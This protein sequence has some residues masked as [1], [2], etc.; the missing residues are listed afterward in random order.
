MPG[1]FGFT[2]DRAAH[3]SQPEAILEAMQEALTPRSSIPDSLFG[4]SWICA[5]RVRG[6]KLQPQPQPA[7]SGE[8]YLWLDGELFNSSEL[9]Q[10]FQLPAGS[11]ASDLEIFLALYQRDPSFTFLKQI[12]GIYSAVLY[13]RAKQ[14][15]YLISDR[16][17]LRPF[18]WAKIGRSL[19]WASEAKAF[20]AMP[21]FQAQIDPAAVEDFLGLRYFIG[22]RSWFKGVELLPAATILSWNLQAETLQQRR[23]WWWDEIAPLPESVNQIEVIEEVGRLFI[24]SVKR[25]TLTPERVGITLSGGLDSRAI[26][27]AMPD[28]GYPIHSVTYGKPGC[29]DVRIASQ[30]AK[31]KASP[32]HIVELNSTNWLQSRIQNVW[33]TD[34]ACSLMHMQ[35]LSALE[36]IRGEDLFDVVLHGTGGGGFLG[37]L[38]LFDP[39]RTDYYVDRQLNLINFARSEAHREAV[40]QRF[41]DYFASLNFSAYILCIDNRIRSFLLKDSR[42][43]FNSGIDCRLP[44]LDNDFQEFLYAIPAAFKADNQL[45]PSMLMRH[46]PEFY[47]HI[48][49]QGLGEPIS[50][51]GLLR[52]T[53]KLYQRVQKKVI[54]EC[55]N[56]G[57]LSQR[58]V[59]PKK[60]ADFH[61]YANWLRQ[62]P[63]RTFVSQL[64]SDRDAIYPEFV[65]REQ[66]QQDWQA[67]LQGQDNNFDRMGQ[68]L[69]FEIWLQQVFNQNYR[70]ADAVEARLESSL[71]TLR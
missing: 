61:D 55:Q 54:R 16:Y 69:T 47:Q 13:D 1:I 3:S 27:A 23:Y 26:L 22:N 35:Y 58:V 6:T 8:L 21:S 40:L 20:L 56:R 70:T 64:L 9:A 29:E 4:D 65:S 59:K 19:A 17:G 34:G 46:F 50:C 49:R 62:E 25:Q 45:Y 12:N 36:K 2:L 24:E 44:F 7:R 41:R 28:P 18:Y 57:L 5:S 15:I 10:T 32:H 71:E 39:N 63:A 33:V 53:Q 31:L 42:L 37:G 48:P 43:S 67:F 60:Q 30:V 11:E 14:Q 38:H 51:P 66:A 68:I 52:Q